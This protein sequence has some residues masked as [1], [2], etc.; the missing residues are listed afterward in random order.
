M[1]AQ[2]RYEYMKELQ[3]DLKPVN[4]PVTFEENANEENLKKLAETMEKMGCKPGWTHECK[5]TI[6][7][8]VNGEIF[9]SM[10]RCD[11]K[12][13]FN[14]QTIYKKDGYYDVQ[15]LNYKN[16]KN[17]D[18]Q[19]LGY[20]EKLTFEDGMYKNLC[21]VNFSVDSS[22]TGVDREVFEK[23]IKV[24][25]IGGISARYKLATEFEK[26]AQPSD[27]LLEEYSKA[28]GLPIIYG[29]KIV[30]LDIKR[31]KEEMI[32]IEKNKGR[33]TTL[34]WPYIIS[35]EVSR[36]I[37]NKPQTKTIK[38]AYTSLESYKKEEKPYMIYMD[39]I[40]GRTGF[41]GMFR[42]QGE[43]YIDNRTFRKENDEYKYDTISYEK[44]MKL[45]GE[46]RTKLSDEA[47]SAVM[48]TFKMPPQIKKIYERASSIKKE[49][50]DSN[51]G[52]ENYH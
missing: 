37:D 36:Q 7:G 20:K 45:A 16:D 44:I 48:G 51:L 31:L 22:N 6:S 18:C 13:I 10:K 28:T 40:D 15:V 34:V 29:E 19:Q 2:K 41:S 39:G 23:G 1:N 50:K 32:E 8:E 30:G 26:F 43:T 33:N 27:E 52:I 3:T 4:I 35:I 9:V 46:M 17:E 5:P 42:L 47:K 14:A 38:Y 49:E 12:E 24:R 25:E 21:L 11:V